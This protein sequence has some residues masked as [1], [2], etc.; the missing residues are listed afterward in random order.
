MDVPIV[1]FVS[2]A[3]DGA[4]V[5]SLVDRVQFQLLALMWAGT[6]CNSSVLSPMLF[7]LPVVSARYIPCD[8]S[9]GEATAL[10]SGDAP[11]IGEGDGPEGSAAVERCI[12]QLL[13][14]SDVLSHELDAA[15]LARCLDV[16]YI[17]GTVEES[18]ELVCRLHDNA[19]AAG[20]GVAVS[21]A[22]FLFFDS[23]SVL[24]GY[25]RYVAAAA[26]DGASP[27]AVSCSEAV[28]DSPSPGNSEI[29][30]HGAPS[31]HVTTRL[32]FCFPAAP[33]LS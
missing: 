27:A 11:Q 8:M 16:C 30:P 19:A 17:A 3:S 32:N 31:N 5:L 1:P 18:A 15:A 14:D 21:D 2:A 33:G 29:E 23:Q 9:R 7:S 4:N 12:P 6:P 20:V 22:L 13:L 10:E 25:R 24:G 26:S 28:F